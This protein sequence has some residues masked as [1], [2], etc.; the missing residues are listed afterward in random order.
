VRDGAVGR[1]LPRSPRGLSA[2]RVGLLLALA[3]AAVAFWT[4]QPVFPTESTPTW[5]LRSYRSVG[6]DKSFKADL[7]AELPAAPELVIFGG[8]RAM[9]FEPSQVGGLTGL[10]AFNCA[11]QCFRPEDAWA[12]SRYLVARSPDTDLHC[13]I[14]LQ[15]RTF[16]R[17]HLRAG[18][19]YD[20]RLS[21]AFP[22]D[23][24]AK[25]QATLASP[26][27]KEVLGGNR[28]SATGAVEY[29]T[30]D[31]ASR[32][33]G[34]S[35]R[36]QIDVSIG[37]LLDN[38]RWT[39]PTR[40]SRPHAYFEAA[41]RLYND[42]GVTPL[43]IMMPVQPRA[44]EA[45]RKLGFQRSLEDLRA[46][47]RDAGTRCR[48]KVLDLTD[49]RTFGGRPKAFYDAV[50]VTRVNARLILKHAVTTAPECF[51]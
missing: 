25:Q 16:R 30:Y 5:Q 21:T 6:F 4:P 47:L 40:V 37:R 20:E 14:A 51:R 35:F 28:Y 22:A 27:V 42:R 18:L 12:F 19:L 31:A 23:L 46:Y 7:L 50:H 26:P 3:A 8:S 15:V 17:D 10:S 11:V 43:I 1:L 38:H 24:M 13:I 34:Y 44:L 48:F 45:F 9:R 39:G 2:L 49:I 32:R 41:M 29:N 33:P 36:R